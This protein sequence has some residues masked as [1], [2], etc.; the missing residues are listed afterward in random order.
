[1]GY[2][3]PAGIEE[4]DGLAD[5]EQVVWQAIARALKPPLRLPL[6]EWTEEN[7][8]I[9]AEAGD[10][11]GPYSLRLAP[12]WREPMECM[13]PM[14]PSERTTV[15][16]SAQLGWTMV[17]AAWMV[18]IVDQWPG[19]L[20]MVH[21]TIKAAGD[22]NREKLSPML[23]VSRVP[24]IKRLASRRRPKAEEIGES[25]Q[26][27]LYK[28]FPGGHWIL[29]GANSAADISSKSARY[30]V[31]EEWDR[32]PED[33][34]GQGDPDE[35]VEARQISYHRSGRG[36]TIQ[37]G[38]PDLMHSSRTWE[39][40]L[41]GDQRRRF[42]KCPHCGHEQELRFFPISREGEPFRGGLRFNMEA[43]HQAHY[44]CEAEGCGGVIEEHEKEWLFQNRGPNNPDGAVWKAQNPG[45]GR[46]PSFY[47]NALW[48]LFTTWDHM[49][50]AF[51][52]A[53]GDPQRLKGFWNLWLGLPWDDRGDVPAA[54]KL[55]D[56]REAY[57]IRT[58]PRG[59]LV[60]TGGADVQSNGIYYEVAAWGRDEQSWSIDYGFIP[61]DPPDPE[62]PCWAELDKVYHRQ[63]RT[64]GGK[65]LG[66]DLFLID[67]GYARA[68][69]APWVKKKPKAFAVR[70]DEGWHKPIVGAPRKED[71]TVNGK[72]LRKSFEIWP[73]GG[74]ALKS[75]FYANLRKEGLDPDTKAFPPGY[76][77]FSLDHEQ[78]F[79]EQVTAESLVENKKA[80]RRMRWMWH[81]NGE[82]HWHD[83]RIYAMAALEHPRLAISR[84]DDAK[85]HRLEALRGGI[86][87]SPQG[88]LAGHWTQPV[89][90]ESPPPASQ[91][92]PDTAVKTPKKRTRG[93][94]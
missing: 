31:K 87:E 71:V 69:V 74:Y 39:A 90:Q 26:T 10:N 50:A 63:Y 22:W 21:P 17:S 36:K 53:K 34:E 70:G 8:V 52:R 2:A 25:A 72:K 80:R 19:P 89:G 60:V 81:A 37:G 6:A 51:V 78:D 3:D 57:G 55:M 20:L 35:L 48:S 56:R 13:S 82:N 59:G 76:C 86:E 49:A 40:F 75:K 7:F 73:V 79:F 91:A 11:A 32:W 43:P 66:I 58:I 41:A 23:R 14:H 84:W 67:G 38:T 45:A 16:K 15:A 24:A 85:W 77:H 64:A 94:A 54:E 33:V 5:A 92:G 83:C 1:M 12:H 65:V 4:L 93:L 9:P 46:Q 62:S 30:I 61:G 27:T 44:V 88:D 47:I 42:L 18:S 68:G 29:T 28:P